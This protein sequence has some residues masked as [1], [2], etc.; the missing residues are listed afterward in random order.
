MTRFD[1]SNWKPPKIE[2]NTPTKWNWIVSHP[3][4]LVLGKYTDIGAFTYLQA[5]EGIAIGDYCQ[6][7][8]NCSIYSVNTIDNCRG[9]I[10][11]EKNARIGSNSVILPGSYIGESSIIGALSLVKGIVPAQEV[12]VGSPARPLKLNRR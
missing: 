4:N 8:A 2:H 5:E 1:D 10:V 6:I 7:G 3:E 11:I 12:W 9:D